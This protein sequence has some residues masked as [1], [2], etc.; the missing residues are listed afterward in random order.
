[1]SLPGKYRDPDL[2][3][4]VREVVAGKENTFDIVLDD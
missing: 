4:L 2:G 3:N 1:M